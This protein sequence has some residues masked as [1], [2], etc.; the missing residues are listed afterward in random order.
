MGPAHESFLAGSAQR[1]R[2]GRRVHRHLRLP[3]LF[4]SQCQR[5]FIISSPGRTPQRL[6]AVGSL[7]HTLG[8]CGA[9][10]CHG[11]SSSN[12]V[13]A[14]DVL[15]VRRVDRLA[16]ST[17][18]LQ[19]IVRTKARACERSNSQSTPAAG[20]F[21]QQLFQ[22]LASYHGFPLVELKAGDHLRYFGTRWRIPTN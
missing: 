21:L 14:R 12:R 4:E 3:L 13:S 5:Y 15:L 17:G 18:D 7:A 10:R 6:E 2:L 22:K 1:V 8:F 16:R 19:D 9:S 11:R 20:K